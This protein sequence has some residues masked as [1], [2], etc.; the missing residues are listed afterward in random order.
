MLHRTA[1]AILGSLPRLT[2]SLKSP[3]SSVSDIMHGLER[4]AH[5]SGEETVTETVSRTDAQT[6]RRQRKRCC[7]DR[8]RTQGGTLSLRRRYRC[9]CCCCCCRISSL[10]IT[11]L[12]RKKHCA[13]LFRFSSQ[14]LL[15][16]EIKVLFN[17]ELSQFFQFDATPRLTTF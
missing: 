3:S 1:L 12:W 9:C 15:L 2:R 13:A 10:F 16:F 7:R 14:N 4:D 11:G 17:F 8:C 6:D 5:G